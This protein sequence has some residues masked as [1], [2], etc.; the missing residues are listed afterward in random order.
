MLGSLLTAFLGF[1]SLAF[2][3]LL[4]RRRRREGEPPLIKGWIPFL[5]KALEFRKDSYQFLQRLQEKHGDVF[6]VLIAGKYMT[7]VMNPLLYPAVI[8]Q[9]KQL[10]FHEFSDAAA[11]TT[12]GYPAV[13]SGRFPGMSERIQK[14]FL[15]LQGPALN[16]LTHRMMGNLQRV[17]RQHFLSWGG[18]PEC[19]WRRDGL[20]EF[21]ERVMF[22]ATF[23]TLYGHPSRAN[24]ETKK[25]SEE[26]CWID[27]LRENFKKFDAKFPLLIAR[28]P[29]GLLGKT[30]SIREELIRFF[31][32]CRMAEWSSPSEFVQMR[33]EL[34]HQYDTLKD[35]DRAAHHFAMLWASVGNTIPACFWCVYHL[36]SDPQAL[37]AVKKEIVDVV[38]EQETSICNDDVTLTR[39]QLDRM[40]YL[41][42]AINESLRLS[43][44]SMNIRVVQ[45]DFCLQLE[46]QCSVCVRKG[47]IVVLHP[48]STHLDPDIYSN[49]QQYQFD[50]FVKDGKEKTE[51]YKGDQ[52]IRYYR[53]PFG[54]GATMCPGRF[55]AI[56]EMK[57]FVCIILL[58][59]DLELA[60]DQQEATLDTSRAGLG[61]LPPAN[62][63]AFRYRLKQHSTEQE[64]EALLN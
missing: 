36:L 46:P 17:V 12:F 13:R 45:E 18:G 7:F 51:F 10:D 5:G 11:S 41:E 60:G 22:E 20:Y 39:E 63:I 28:V 2:L 37:V 52:K 55:F 9:G 24:T 15:L 50:R 30:K 27:T 8:K 56:N 19:D 53:M 32:P 58:M 4:L 44:A 42:S 26:I 59:C 21:C 38:G 40:I 14:L 61:I 16:S 48:Q 62:H 25:T 47:D 31:H 57:Q 6:T 1:A 3:H 34:F 35:L 29:I 54:S 33:T 23:L 49:P 43:S 64:A